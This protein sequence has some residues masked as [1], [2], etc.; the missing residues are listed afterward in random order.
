MCCIVL[1]S[2]PVPFSSTCHCLHVCR[3]T[4]CIIYEYR[5][6]PS[7]SDRRRIGIGFSMHFGELQT[8]RRTHSAN[9][10][11]Q[12]AFARPSH[13]LIINRIYKQD[14]VGCGSREVLSLL[15][16][17]EDRSLIVQCLLRMLLALLCPLLL[18]LLFLAVCC[19]FL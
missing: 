17:R 4:V 13:F 12:R 14:A 7:D 10:G 9:T 2:S 15:W 5:G 18:I 19:L 11:R 1:R 3:S 8:Q 16:E 6:Q